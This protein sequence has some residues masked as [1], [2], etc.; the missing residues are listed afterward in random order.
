MNITFLIGNGFDINLG[1]KTSF[2]D[3]LE[4]YKEP[5]K[6]DTDVIKKFKTDFLKDEILWSNAELAFGKITEDFYFNNMTDKDFSD[7]HID[8]CE[9]LGEYLEK[10]ESKLKIEENKLHLDF[11]SAIMNPTIGLSKLAATTIE[12]LMSPY[13]AVNVFNFVSFNYTR[14]IDRFVKRIQ[15]TAM[16]NGPLHVR[17][18]G[19]MLIHVHGYTDSEMM[20][21]VSNESQISNKTLFENQYYKSQLIK[22]L[23]NNLN[24]NGVDEATY[25]LLKRSDLIYIYGMSLGE[26]DSL[27]W[28]RI[29]AL[30]FQNPNLIVV[31]YVHKN[32]SQ[33]RV[34]RDKIIFRESKKDEF[35][36]FAELSDA[37]KE[38]I[39]KRVYITFDNIFSCLQNLETQEKMIEVE[40]ME[41]E[42]LDTQVKEALVETATKLKGDGKRRLKI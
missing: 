35:L 21:G 30:L 10:Q 19:G 27:W 33:N 34:E 39:K 26:T 15:N 25:E 42:A 23:W 36:R 9:R 32:F 24:E 8:F 5:R 11:S 40:R 18:E 6:D 7:C 12:F 29:G 14:T 3:F 2:S 41:K 16:L 22:P 37:A 13:G 31:I 4:V 38:E 20:L 28:E 1:L 17:S